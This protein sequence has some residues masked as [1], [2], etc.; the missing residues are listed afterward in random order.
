VASGGSSSEL[1]SFKA[2]VA[3]ILKS[4]KRAMTPNKQYPRITL[5][6]IDG[7]LEVSGQSELGLV[8]ESL[9]VDTDRS[10]ESPQIHINGG[11]IVDVLSA[12]EYEIAE[13]RCSTASSPIFFFDGEDYSLALPLRH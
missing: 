9:E 1:I 4:V 10:K 5:R 6:L 11:Y 12:F 13:I 7:E 3:Q 8:S 2:P